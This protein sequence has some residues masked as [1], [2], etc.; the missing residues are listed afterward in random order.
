M[1]IGILAFLAAALSAYI[2]GSFPT[3]Y[4]LTKAIKGTDIRTSGSGNAGATNVLR[5]VGKIPALV[6]LLIDIFKGAFAVVMLGNFFYGYGI[7]LDYNFYRGLLGLLVVSGHI[8]PVFL[9]FKGGKGVATAIGVGFV[10]APNALWPS[11]AIWVIV[12]FIFNYVSLAS[13]ISLVAFPIIAALTNYSIYTILFSI[14]ISGLSI[15]RH[16]SNVDRLLKGQEHKI[17]I[18]K[19]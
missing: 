1:L 2:V 3:S 7:D 11:V 18:S 13:I 15:L 4:I 16:K 17:K 6:T 9:K 14:A 5:T 10:L 19:S 8:W 12:F